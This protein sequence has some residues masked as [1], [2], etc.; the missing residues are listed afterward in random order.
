MNKA[1]TSG[2]RRDIETSRTGRNVAARVVVL[3]GFMGAGKTTVGRAL[4][5]RLGWSFEDLD[6]RI[7]TRENRTIADIFQEGGEAAFRAAEKSALH[8][9][10][11]EAGSGSRRILAVGG[12][13][14]AQAENAS[15]LDNADTPTIFLDAPAKEL[16]KR[17][18]ADPVERPLRR[19]K[20]EFL[21]L[22][23]AR[24]PHYLRAA[25]RVETGGRN[26]EHIVSEIVKRLRLELQ[27]RD[28]EK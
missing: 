21:E 12:G 28:G 22:Y 4:G 14:F 15:L 7:Q 2:S 11:A 5:Q 26:V 8:E 10:L 3:V 23:D 16:W 9:A 6:D 17:C 24:R 20:T 19:Q 18:S 25:L 13:A 1:D 27:L